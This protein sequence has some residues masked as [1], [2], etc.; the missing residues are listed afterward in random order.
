MAT[1]AEMMAEVSL[2]DSDLVY[3]FEDHGLPLALQY[4]L[5]HA[6]FN[7][8]RRFI[9]LGDAKATFRTAV[10]AELQLDA[11]T[12]AGM[13]SLSTLVGILDA[14]GQGTTKEITLRANRKP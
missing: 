10:A 12:P 11:N 1:E 7:S 13:L 14:A 9:G 4:S 5:V 8:L 2:A 3:F 6:G